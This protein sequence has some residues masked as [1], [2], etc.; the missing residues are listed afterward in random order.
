[1]IS[2]RFF[3]RLTAG[4]AVLIVSGAAAAV[5][6]VAASA[7]PGDGTLTITPPTGTDQTTMS[8]TTSGPCPAGVSDSY[9]VEV[10]GPG[11]FSGV[12]SGNS[13]AGYSDTAP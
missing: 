5:T 6:A 7:A 11:T 1:M 4:A 9:D 10:Q 2:G 3:R 8:G 13:S 12:L